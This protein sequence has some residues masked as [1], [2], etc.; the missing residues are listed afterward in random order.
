MACQHI[1]E[2]RAIIDTA[3]AVSAH[4]DLAGTPHAAP[5]ARLFLREHLRHRLP[6]H[7]LH[8]VELLTT[9]LVTNV[10]IHARTSVHLGLSWDER[11]LLVT[12]LDNDAV[13][14]IERQQHGLDH[15]QESGRGLQVIAAIADDFGWSRLPD[16]SG[17]VTWFA[18]ALPTALPHQPPAHGATTK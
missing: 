11:N 9:E 8:T 13:G 3:A 5:L 6:A 2:Q 1:A 16:G 18:L 7:L 14:P 15:E 12:V 4:T 17:K 10:V